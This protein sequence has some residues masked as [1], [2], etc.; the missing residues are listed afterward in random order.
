MTAA[1]DAR[2]AE[3]AVWLSRLGSDRREPEVADDFIAWLDASDENRAAFDI[4]NESWELAGG[5]GAEVREAPNA[6]AEGWSRI[7]IAALCAAFVVLASLLFLSG[8]GSVIE[9]QP[10]ER[11][12]IV[13]EDGSTTT[14]NTATRIEVA[15]ENRRRTITLRDGEASFQVAHDS[16]RPFVVQAGAM[17]IVAVGT[18]FD[19]RWTS[20]KLRV[21]VAEGV[22]R[23]LASSPGT[24]LR[25][26]VELRPG[27]Q[28][29]YDPAR[30]LL[31]VQQV[32]LDSARAWRDGRLVF[33]NMRLG[34]A[35]AEI[36][37]YGGKPIAAD[38]DV[39]SRLAISGAFDT[40]PPAFARA[41]AQLYGLRLIE[42]DDRLLL[43]AAPDSTGR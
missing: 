37:R 17:D 23:V 11:R 5:I 22:V 3:A 34:D 38:A 26:E 15:F 16:L 43:R 4:V 30:A 7:A 14:L 24:A 13:L 8:G 41:V 35:L 18:E 10:G 29:I 32:D 6:V 12:S 27:Q 19:V 25:R 39:A 20:D 28:L 1:D 2:I 40:R 36:N 33:D 21:T 9:T 31:A 42:T